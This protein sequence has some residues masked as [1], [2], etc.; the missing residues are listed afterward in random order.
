MKRRYLFLAGLLLF[1]MSAL[2][3]IGQLP[4]ESVDLA[5]MAKIRE[6]G[7]ERSQ[8]MQI[9]S[10]LTDGF[11][12][13]LTNSPNI[14]AAAQWT[15][16]KMSGWGMT[17]LRL[18]PW[19]PFGRGWT[20]ERTYISLIKPYA[21]PL[22]GYPR[23]WTP[24]TNGFVRGDAVIAI[25]NTPEDME[26][27]RGKLRGK[28]VMNVAAANVT[29][30]FQAPGVRFTDQ[31]LQ[32]LATPPQPAAGGGR[33]GGGG[34]GGQGARGNQPPPAKLPGQLCGGV[35]PAPPAPRGQQAAPGQPA[36]PSFAVV[37][38]QFYIS[39]GILGLVGHGQ[40]AGS[41]AGG[42]VFVQSA[43]NRGV[44]DPAVPAY[45]SLA[46]EHYGLLARNLA[47]GIP[48]AL[49]MNIENKF[50]DEDLNSYNVVGE[51]RGTDKAD[52][53]VMIGAH[54]DSWHTGTGATDNAAGSAV[55]MEA[56]RIL[57]ATQVPLRRTVR[58][59]LWTG[60]EQGLFGS[61][62]YVREHFGTPQALKPDH[63]K[64]SA[65]FNVDNG[66]GQIRGVY[67]EGNEG[68]RPIFEA[69]MAP[70]KDFTMTTLTARG[71]GGTDH[72]N[73]DS[74]GLPGFQFIQDRIEY[75][76]RT[77]H[78]NMD[79]FERIQAKDMMQNAV[80]VASFVYNAANREQLLPRKPLPQGRGGRGQ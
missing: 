6:E 31:Q 80:I 77:H 11:G 35:L 41:V 56:M 79:M 57:K 18:E 44:N 3:V 50:H 28:F 38:N 8:V 22:I 62:A 16:Q 30:Q 2:P 4:Q 12:P 17:N 23:A 65:Y 78:S 33:G 49:E 47:N 70:F 29:P 40:A 52:E 1:A 73:F 25:I 14:K 24:G 66:T 45:V 43:G 42:T 26:D 59:A 60:E 9:T 10:A 75:D 64:M 67:M 13:R 61:Q 72:T 55:M 21:F 34:G 76:T 68:V 54:F 19:G 74:A 32:T 7:I 20:N 37:R 71:T 39:E 58:I 69:W 27:C 53:V 36:P 46:A 63:A 5:A 51:I 48:V 15:L